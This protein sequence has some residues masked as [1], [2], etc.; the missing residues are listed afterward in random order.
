MEEKKQITI[1]LVVIFLLV[2]G[3]FLYYFFFC[4]KVTL[5]LP[6]PPI[7]GEKTWAFLVNG[8]ERTPGD[9]IVV[10]KSLKIDVVELEKG[11][12]V[13]VDSGK[14]VDS[15]KMDDVIENRDLLAYKYSSEQNNREES[16]SV[17]A[18]HENGVVTLVFVDLQKEEKPWIHFANCGRIIDSLAGIIDKT[19][20]VNGKELDDRYYPYHQ[21]DRI[22]LSIKENESGEIIGEIDITD[23]VKKYGSIY[24]KKSSDLLDGE[25]IIIII[26]NPSG[27]F[28]YDTQEI[29]V[30]ISSSLA[31]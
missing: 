2:T 19:V 23:R 8:K 7:D 22:I 12:D 10:W 24:F 21:G 9:V 25:E 15:F 1:S 17:V 13:P 6:R 16:L 27:S 28:T 3:V 29:E 5:N 31:V 14:I 20:L 11:D 30:K 26:S 4:P 18:Y